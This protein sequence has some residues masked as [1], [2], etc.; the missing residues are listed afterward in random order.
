MA[1]DS[2]AGGKIYIIGIGDDGLDGITSAAR[3]LITSASLLV[4][5]D[6][7]LGLIPKSSAERVVLGANLEPVVA[8]LRA[9]ASGTSVLMPRP[10]STSARSCSFPSS[11][12][13]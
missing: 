8:R 13:T 5:S 6:H 10:P 12:S 4:G 2:Q 1:N 3:G 9:H 11:S 7:T